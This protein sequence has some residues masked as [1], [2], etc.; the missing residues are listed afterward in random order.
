MLALQAV[1]L[2]VVKLV[3]SS[4]LAGHLV[5]P[6]VVDIDQQTVGDGQHGPWLAASARA[7]VRERMPVR[8]GGAGDRRGDRAQDGLQVGVALGGRTTELFAG[9]APVAGTDPSPR[10]HMARAGKPRLSLSRQYPYG[11]VELPRCGGHQ[12]AWG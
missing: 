11:A 2:E 6:H 5:A 1:G 12:Y 7:A 3:R 8:A 9:A 4:V 10:S